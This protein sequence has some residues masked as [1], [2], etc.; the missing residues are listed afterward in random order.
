MA[1][2]YLLAMR[3]SGCDSESNS[4]NERI[5]YTDEDLP[6]DVA[7]EWMGVE[8]D[9]AASP[10]SQSASTAHSSVGSWQSPVSGLQT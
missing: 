8:E 1:Y 10:S 4:E 2:V 6:E 7:L 3:D 5:Y 9:E